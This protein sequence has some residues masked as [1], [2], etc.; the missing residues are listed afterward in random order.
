MLLK[1]TGVRAAAHGA[2]AEATT[3]IDAGC[4][5]TG[6]LRLRESVRI[7]GC[8]EGEIRGEKLVVVGESA[9]IQASIHADSVVVRGRVEGEIHARRKITLHATAHVV[10]DMRT[11]GITIEEGAS[12]E[13]RIE[14]GRAEPEAPPEPA[15]A[16]QQGSPGKAEAA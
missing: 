13:G 7:D 15:P 8:V 4:R 9:H 14:I 16:P 3:T 5:F 10:S 2:G 12:F 1:G 6:E 11:A